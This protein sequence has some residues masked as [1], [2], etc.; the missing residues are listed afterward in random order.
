MEHHLASRGWQESLDMIKNRFCGADAMHR[1]DFVA[2]FGA[3]LQYMLQDLLLQ[4]ERLVEAR[5]GIETNFTDVAS[6]WQ[7]LIP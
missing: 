7:V 2:G 1:D 4:L 5:T 3:T 6:L